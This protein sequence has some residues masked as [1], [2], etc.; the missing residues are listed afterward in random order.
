MRLIG[1]ILL[2]K[3]IDTLIVLARA[4]QIKGYAV[5]FSDADGAQ[6]SQKGV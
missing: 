2:L 1:E 4:A 6:P 5:D 3:V